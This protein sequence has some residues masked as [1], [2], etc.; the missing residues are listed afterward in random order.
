MLN[1]PIVTNSFIPRF[2]LKKE[3]KTEPKEEKKNEAEKQGQN[4]DNDSEDEEEIEDNS[5]IYQY[6]NEKPRDFIA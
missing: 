6:I 1:L 3:M 4:E 2:A 5:F